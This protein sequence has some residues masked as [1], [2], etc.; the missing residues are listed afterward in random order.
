MAA[1]CA[2]ARRGDLAPNLP[3]PARRSRPQRPGATNQRPACPA[4]RSIG[5]EEG[6]GVGGVAHARWA[7][8]SPDARGGAAGLGRSP[9]VSRTARPCRGR[10]V[11]GA[12]TAGRARP[13]AP[14]WPE[15]L[16]RYHCA[17]RRGTRVREPGTGRGIGSP[18]GA[19]QLQVDPGVG[20]G[21]GRICSGSP[22]GTLPP[23]SMRRGRRE[24]R[25]EEPEQGASAWARKGPVSCS[26]P[27]PLRKRPISR[28]CSPPREESVGA[29]WRAGL[30]IPTGPGLG[31]TAPQ[32][33]LRAPLA[34]PLL[35]RAPNQ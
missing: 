9:L 13:G 15:L 24:F 10:D 21:A 4:A 22:P 6:R 23:V 20:R 11:G 34:C 1:G 26:V 30:L 25:G 17:T 14:L 16:L 33:E 35:A 12:E 31:R 27:A 29:G 5:Q 7:G 3:R 2:A 32:P 18:D 8:L 28:V 19:A